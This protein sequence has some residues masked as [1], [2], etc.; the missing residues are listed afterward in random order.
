MKLSEEIGKA[1]GLPLGLVTFTVS[2]LRNARTFHP[3]GV[4]AHCEVKTLEGSPVRFHPYALARFTGAIWKKNQ[5]LPDVLGISLRFTRNPVSATEPQKSDQD[6]LFASFKWPIQTPIGPFITRFSKFYLNSF[7][8]VSPFE[9]GNETGRFRLII[10]EKATEGRR[11]ENMLENIRKHAT[12]HLWFE[13]KAVADIILVEEKKLD[14]EALTFNPYRSGL[15]IHPRG[16]IHALRIFVYPMSQSGRRL[17]HRFQEVLHK[18]H[19]RGV[20][21]GL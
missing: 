12:L 7:Y 18:T 11:M 17:R 2:F 13:D 10:E 19:N 8:A 4:L 5:F 21:K 3:S 20:I 9:I 16:F 14:Q 15:R 1:L 6:L